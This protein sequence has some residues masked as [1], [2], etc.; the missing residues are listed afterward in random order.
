MLGQNEPLW[1]S[2]WPG[3]PDYYSAELDRINEIT[4]T[5]LL[6]H[7][8]AQTLAEMLQAFQQLIPRKETRLEQARK[9]VAKIAVDL[10]L[11]MVT[12]GVSVAAQRFFTS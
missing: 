4:E 6:T 7:T 12:V 9:W 11:I 3:G 2:H 1:P 5:E 10:F 8:Q